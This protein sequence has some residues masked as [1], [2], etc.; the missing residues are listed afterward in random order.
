M[1]AS[2]KKSMFKTINDNSYVSIR[3]IRWPDSFALMMTNILF[4][5]TSRNLYSSGHRNPY[6]LFKA[7]LS[8]VTPYIFIQ[9]KQ[10]EKHSGAKVS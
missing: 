3:A 2:K 5:Q 10:P 7:T 4:A 6:S 8:F 1:N 9:K